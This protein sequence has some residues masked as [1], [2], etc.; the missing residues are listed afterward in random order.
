MKA[1][2]DKDYKHTER[3]IEEALHTAH[4]AAEALN[5]LTQ[6]LG[7]FNLQDY[8][9]I[10]GRVG[11]SDL[12]T[13]AEKAI[14]RLG[15]SVLPHGEAVRI[16]VPEQLQSIRG[17]APSYEA[18]TFDRQVAMRKRQTELMGIGHPLIDALLSFLQSPQVSGELTSR[19]ADDGGGAKLVVRALISIE[20][21][22]RQAH[23]EV[24]VI[25]IDVNG[26][27]TLLP[28]DWDLKW[29]EDADKSKVAHE[30]VGL[31]LE[32]WRGTYESTIGALLTQTRVKVENPLA[33]RVKLLGLSVVV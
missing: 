11:L 16:E 24:K 5:A 20:G 9:R 15:G 4:E 7:A 19:K 13:F 27:V 32:I 12:R 2:V 6:D 30:A 23:N 28:E 14:L 1:L 33:A 25:Q 17:V 21:E 22:A 29:L 3:E 18:A 8:L 10:E 31:S 26:A